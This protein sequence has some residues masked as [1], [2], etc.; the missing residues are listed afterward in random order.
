MRRRLLAV[1]LLVLSGC[2][3]VPVHSAPY[4]AE[5][6]VDGELIGKT[7]CKFKASTCLW[8][9][10]VVEVRAPG[11]K[12][13]TETVETEFGPGAT[14]NVLASVIFLS[15]LIILTPFFGDVVPGAVFAPLEP[16][17]APPLVPEAPP[18]PERRSGATGEGEVH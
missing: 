13:Y 2:Q 9:E 14:W 18:A 16:A 7:P 1:A 5:V 11:F 10:Y 12:T 3:S 4:G 8:A 15:P 6:Y 17:D